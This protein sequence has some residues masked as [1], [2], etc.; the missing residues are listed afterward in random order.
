[1]E[2]NV[3][4]FERSKPSAGF[5]KQSGTPGMGRRGVGVAPAK[6]QGVSPPIAMDF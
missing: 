3:D 2:V 4:L 6:N 5:A 1:M